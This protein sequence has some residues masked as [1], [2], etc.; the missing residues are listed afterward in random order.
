MNTKPP[1][2]IGDASTRYNTPLSATEE[3]Q[4]QKW[5][6]TLPVNL[7]DDYDYD[8]RGAWLAKVKPDQYGHMPDLYKKPWHPTFSMESYYSVPPNEGGDWDEDNFIPSNTNEIMDAIRQSPFYQYGDYPYVNY[9]KGGKIPSKRDFKW[10]VKDNKKYNREPVGN[11]DAAFE[12]NPETGEMSG[13]I[14]PVDIYQNNSREAA[15]ARVNNYFIKHPEAMVDAKNMRKYSRYYSDVAWDNYWQNFAQNQPKTWAG[16]YDMSNPYLQVLPDRYKKQMFESN[17]RNRGGEEWKWAND[18]SV[19]L[20]MFPTW[21]VGT[22]LNNTP[23]KDTIFDNYRLIRKANNTFKGY[24]EIPKVY[25][26]STKK[27]NSAL[28]KRIAEHNTYVRGIRDNETLTDVVAKKLNID[29]KLV[30]PDDRLRYMATH[31]APDTNHGR[32]GMEDLSKDTGVLYTSNSIDTAAGYASLDG[33]SRKLTGELDGKVAVV[34]R[35]YQLGPDREMWITQGD[36]PLRQR[37]RI[38]EAYAPYRNRAHEMPQ[39]LKDE[40]LKYVKEKNL[41]VKN[42]FENLNKPNEVLNSALDDFLIDNMR[43][44]KPVT[45]DVIYTTEAPWDPIVMDSFHKRLNSANRRLRKVAENNF[46]SLY[47]HYIFTGPVGEKGLDFVRF[48]DPSEIKTEFLTRT[49][50]G[51]FTPGLSR[52]QYAKGGSIHIKPENRGKFTALKER[53]GHSATWFKQNGTPAQK[54]MATFALNAAKWKHK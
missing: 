19:E 52:K 34:R 3:A 53:T 49:H 23:I 27:T 42:L 50:E 26:F 40:V 24:K 8:L 29:P 1:K 43:S 2:R 4:Y 54:K 5:V 6:K 32:A 10:W 25:S 48:L 9:D 16:N 47:Q 39:P 13:Y 31:Y 51:A 41:S 44:Y 12:V 15:I 33:S 46:D 18:L 22:N 11:S 30:T 20:A 28:K 37:E 17:I 38:V 14:A 21:F 36:I 35:P 7:R 45:S